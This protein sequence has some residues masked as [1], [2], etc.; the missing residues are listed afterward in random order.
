MKTLL[1]TLAGT[2]FIGSTNFP[3]WLKGDKTNPTF[4][5]TIVQKNNKTVLLDEVN[6]SKNGKTKTITGYDYPDATDSTAFVWRGKGLLWLAKSHWKV[7]LLDPDGQWAVIWFSK[8][9]FTPEGVDI[10]S[11]NSNLSPDAL[12][13]IRLLMAKDPVLQHHLSSLK[14]L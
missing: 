8:T 14:P 10:I 2:W 6:Y 7:A 12:S 3:M 4:N 11:R 13:H 1:H 9:L 5:Y